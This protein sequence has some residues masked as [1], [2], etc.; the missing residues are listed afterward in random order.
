[1]KKALGLFLSSIILAIGLNG[2]L[3]PY[4][5]LDGGVIGLGLII[6]YTTGI[7]TGL[8]ILVLSL[9]IYILSLFIERSIFI[10]GI[11]GLLLSSL[12]IDAL[13]PL[14]HLFH[15][16]VMFSAM[17]GGILVGLGVGIMLKMGVST[18]GLDLLALFI[19]RI[20]GWN[21]GVLIFIIDSI[22]IL[23]GYAVAGISISY[24]IIT[25]VFVGLMTTSINSSRLTIQKEFK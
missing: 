15:L 19:S 14:Q 10:K 5:L 17:I 12:S 6:N 4:H 25:I 2:F 13:G 3:A 9:P 16:P 22:I 20:T 24:S 1:M 21:V 11:H 7:Q 23:L 18:G 8:A